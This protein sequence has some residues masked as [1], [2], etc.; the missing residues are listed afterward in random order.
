MRGYV[1]V[2]IDGNRYMQV[3]WVIADNF[4]DHTVDPEKLKDIGAIWGSWKTWRAWN[5]DNV[6]CFN[7]EKARDLV[8]R[9][10]HAVCNLYVQE[11][12]FALL[13]RP[14]GVNIYAG[15][16]PAEFDNEEEIV[17]MHLLADNADI[18]LLL[19]YNLNL[20]DSDDKYLMHKRKNYNAAFSAA[21]KMYP[22]TQ[23]VLLDH[24]ELD[25]NLKN[26]E[27]LT[28]DTLENV[29]ELLSN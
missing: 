7:I 19:G 8:T 5:T 26:L 3:S 23:W 2:P 17:A 21:V 11:S 10:F 25:D 1:W 12:A 16:F 28:C 20:P 15:T 18:V 22:D 4:N 29:L 13:D 14:N 9:A 6:I 27:N 24:S